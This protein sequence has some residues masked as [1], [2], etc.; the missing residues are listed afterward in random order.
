ME[1]GYSFAYL[2]ADKEEGLGFNARH[3]K[4]ICLGMDY[5]LPLHLADVVVVVA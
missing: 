5:P 4:K 3:A 1:G 2:R